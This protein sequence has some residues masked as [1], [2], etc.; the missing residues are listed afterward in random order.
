MPGDNKDSRERGNSGSFHIWE[1]IP[2]AQYPAGINHG[3][4]KELGEQAG[5]GSIR[6]VGCEFPISLLL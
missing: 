3:L 2:E 1:W 4:P 6:L 5:V